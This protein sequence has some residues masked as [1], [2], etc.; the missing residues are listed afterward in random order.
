M[1]GTTAANMTRPS[2]IHEELSREEGVLPSSNRSFGLVIGVALLLAG[3]L[4]LVWGGRTRGWM[5]LLGAVF[6]V[7]AV[8]APRVLGPLNV[9]WTRLG[10]LLH[11]VASL[12]AMGVIFYGIITPMGAAM[13]WL[14]RDPLR[15]R[16]GRQSQTYW[17]ERRPPGPSPE[18]MRAQ[19]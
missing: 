19:F 18:T 9:L 6:L 13:R 3:L 2:A 10:L 7:L 16:L 5:G 1:D 11:G 15:L 17:I 12:I 4:P 14:G 8:A